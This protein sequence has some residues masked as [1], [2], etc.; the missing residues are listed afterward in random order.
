MDD[1]VIVPERFVG[2]LLFRHAVVVAERF[3]F[4]ISGLDYTVVVAEGLIAVCGSVSRIAEAG[5][6]GVREDD[7][8]LGIAAAH[9]VVRSRDAERMSFM[10]AKACERDCGAGKDIAMIFTTF[11]AHRRYFMRSPSASQK[12]TRFCGVETADLTTY[13]CWC[14]IT[15][16]FRGGDDEVR[17]LPRRHVGSCFGRRREGLKPHVVR[18]RL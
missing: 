7:R 2:V 8:P 18:R 17:P 9:A 1:A 5:G 4:I 6:K 16:S 15:G 12:S 13:G 3:V 10:V 11:S 14:T